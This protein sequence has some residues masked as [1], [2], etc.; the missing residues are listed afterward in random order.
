[1]KRNKILITAA[2]SILLM[3]IATIPVSSSPCCIVVVRPPPPKAPKA[4][5]ENLLP[6]HGWI[7]SQLPVLAAI[8]KELF[9]ASLKMEIRPLPFHEAVA[10]VQ[11]KQGALGIDFLT[12]LATYIAQSGANLKV[13]SVNIN[14]PYYALFTKPGGPEKLKDLKGKNIVVPQRSTLGYIFVVEALRLAGFNEKD[15]KFTHIP[16]RVARMTAFAA[17]KFDAALLLTGDDDVAK[18]YGLKQ[19]EIPKPTKLPSWVTYTSSETLDKETEEINKFIKGVTKGIN[20][21]KENSKLT[22]NIL[23]KQFKITGRIQDLMIKKYIPLILPDNI[24]P[25]PKEINQILQ[26]MQSMNLFKKAP[27]LINSQQLQELYK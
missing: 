23:K 15:I 18:D 16:Q 21:V 17:G 13:T 8:E 6:S 2:M 26:V 7:Y 27:V 3:L 22:R 25:E 20:I 19:I 1:M 10:L 4:Q 24:R 5:K 9:D 12:T 14:Q 11:S